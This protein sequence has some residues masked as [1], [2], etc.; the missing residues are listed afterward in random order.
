MKLPASITDGTSNTIMIGEALPRVNQDHLG[1][2]RWWEYNSGQSH[3]TTIIPI[4]YIMPEKMGTSGGCDTATNNWN[5]T[6]GFS[7]RH[8]GGANFV[9]ADGS[10]HFLAQSINHM[11]YNQLGCRND[12]QPA[13]IP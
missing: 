13:Q 10:V 6:W 11:T 12:G 5:I 1:T 3:Y 4:N 9:F 8:S 2:N 7:S